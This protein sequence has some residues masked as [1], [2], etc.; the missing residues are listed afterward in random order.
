[1]KQRSLSGTLILLSGLY[2]TQ[3][4]ADDREGSLG[5]DYG[6]VSVK[7][8]GGGGSITMPSIRFNAFDTTGGLTAGIRGALNKNAAQKAKEIEIENS[9]RNGTTAPDGSSVSRFGNTIQGSYTYSWTQPEPTPTDGDRW[10]LTF[11][12]NGTP[13]IDAISPPTSSSKAVDSMLGIEYSSAL[14]S[15]VSA[16]LSFSAGWGMK[17]FVFSAEGNH[18]GKAGIDSDSASLPINASISSHIW[19]DMVA[20]GDFAVSPISLFKGKGFYMHEEVGVEWNF[21]SD[22]LLTVNY[23]LMQDALNDKDA[24]G[25]PIEYEMNMAYAGIGYGF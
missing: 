8:K 13:I 15:H 1:M 23:R 6:I 4:F 12:T 10:L 5:I 14:W 7:G 16:P 18:G 24:S 17:F 11:A 19:K 2:C 20:Y 25:D 21:V 3:A 9:V 22:W